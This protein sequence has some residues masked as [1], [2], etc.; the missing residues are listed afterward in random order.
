MEGKEQSLVQKFPP[1][2]K[3][4]AQAKITMWKCVLSTLIHLTAD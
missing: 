4:G 2:H 3:F 1:G